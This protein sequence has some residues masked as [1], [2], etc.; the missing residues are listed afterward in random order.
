MAEA[1]RL[2]DAFVLAQAILGGKHLNV[3]YRTFS[4]RTVGDSKALERLEGAV[5]RLLGGI[6]EFPPEAN[7]TSPVPNNIKPAQ[8]T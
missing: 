6:I 1:D 2:R 3:D 5:V 8:Q 7:T 4:R